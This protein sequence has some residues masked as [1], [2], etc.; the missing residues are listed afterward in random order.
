MPMR[1]FTDSAGMVW[2]VWETVPRVGGAYDE[3]L[4]HGWLTFE[5]AAGTRKRLA[6]IPRDWDKAPDERLELMCRI[7][8]EGRGTGATRD[9]DAPPETNGETPS[10]KH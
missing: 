10:T 4:R 9:P 3:S 5:S 2:R 8:E 7:A 6:P 1:E